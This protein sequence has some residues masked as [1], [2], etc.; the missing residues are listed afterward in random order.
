MNWNFNIQQALGPKTVLQMA[1][2]ANHGVKLYSVTD[3]NQ[4]NPNSPFKVG[5]NSPCDVN[6]G[7]DNCEGPG[8]PLNENCSVAQG[9]LGRG[10][11]CFPYIGYL[12]YLSNRSNSAYNSL[13]V[14]LTHR[15]SRGLY[16]LVG[17][18]YAHAIDTATSNLAGVPPD[19]NNYAEERGNGDYDIRHRVTVSLTYNLPDVK[20]K[21][22]LLEGWQVATVA[23]LEGGLPYTLGDFNDDI[24]LTG[25][26]NDRWNMSGPA[27]NIHW[28][29]T[30]GIPFIDPSTFGTD[31]SGNITGNTQCINAAGGAT[32]TGAQQLSQLRVFCFG[33][34]GDYS[35]GLSNS[36]RYGTK[37]FPWPDF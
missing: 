10:G 25:E 19:S 12:D 27:S 32:S 37:H 22:Q 16:M 3:I 31:S 9:G 23:M 1:Y 17:Y 8:R 18:T 11:P 5:T 28:S 2:V 20:S 7:F 4:V 13:Q 24:S 29:P 14:T 35:A 36:R 15:Y 30:A 6:A 26:F 34:H 33:Q 21:W